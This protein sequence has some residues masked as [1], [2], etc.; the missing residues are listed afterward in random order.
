VKLVPHQFGCHAGVERHCCVTGA[1]RM[2]HIPFH[3]LKQMP[4]NGRDLHRVD[5][6]N[7]TDGRKRRFV[8]SRIPHMPID[9]GQNIFG[10]GG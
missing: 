4:Q 6:P 8:F 10:K 9:E 3:E 1:S 7:C 5:S 2:R